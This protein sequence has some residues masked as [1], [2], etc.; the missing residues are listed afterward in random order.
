ML[1][2]RIVRLTAKIDQLEG[3]LISLVGDNM[4]NC[5]DLRNK[6]LALCASPP[7]GFSKMDFLVVELFLTWGMAAIAAKIAENHDG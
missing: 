6:V 4:D 2:P 7:K 3:D 1:D 5:L